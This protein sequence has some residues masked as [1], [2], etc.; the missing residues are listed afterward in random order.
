MRNLP[1]RV[2]KVP[3]QVTDRGE[4]FSVPQLITR[5]KC[6]WKQQKIIHGG[7]Q[8]TAFVRMW[9]ENKISLKRLLGRRSWQIKL[10]LDRNSETGANKCLEGLLL[11]RKNDQL[12]G[13]IQNHIANG[14]HSIA[15]VNPQQQTR[16]CCCPST[17]LM[18]LQGKVGSCPIT[19]Q[20]CGPFLGTGIW[21]E[22]ESLT[23]ST[24]NKHTP[25]LIQVEQW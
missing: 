4:L 9:T 11:G 17:F 10:E 1:V 7:K 8:E 5:K 18:R 3:E 25:L 20:S 19:N 13:R 22:R 16:T 6:F 21:G 24:T 15:T 12:R 23:H 14:R 2:F